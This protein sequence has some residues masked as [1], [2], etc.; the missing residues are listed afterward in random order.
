MQKKPELRRLELLTE[1]YKS[2]TIGLAIMVATRGFPNP[3]GDAVSGFFFPD[4][5]M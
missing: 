3:D 4:H 1:G 5:K 2:C